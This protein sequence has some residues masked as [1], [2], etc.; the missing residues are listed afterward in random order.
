L[1]QLHVAMLQCVAMVC[2]LLVRT[3]AGAHATARL[4]QDHEG[5]AVKTESRREVSDW[6]SSGDPILNVPV[7]GRELTIGSLYDARTD[8]PVSGYLLPHEVLSSPQFVRETIVKHT[9]YKF[10]Y[11][12]IVDA[13]ANM[14]DITGELKLSF[15]SGWLD[16]AGSARFLEDKKDICC[17]QSARLSISSYLVLRLRGTMQIFVKTLKDKTITLNAAAS[18]TIDSVKAMFQH[19]NRV[20]PRRAVLDS[21]GQTGRRRLDHD[22]L[23]LPEVAHFVPGSA[24]AGRDADLRE[25]PQAQ[26]SHHGVM[27]AVGLAAAATLLNAPVIPCIMTLSSLVISPVS[28]SSSA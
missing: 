9:D 17:G 25:D 16:S 11:D 6:D 27:K 4:S 22:R 13:K 12:D 10:L 14:L 20:P 1:A 5:T 3:I 26:D 28:T 8:Q 15:F 24:S 23:Q 7:L 18:V 2:Q 19:M 21:G